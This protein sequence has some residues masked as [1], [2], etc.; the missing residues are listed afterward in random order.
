MGEDQ[1]LGEAEDM[2]G[3]VAHTPSKKIRFEEVNTIY[4]QLHFF[5]YPYPRPSAYIVYFKYNLYNL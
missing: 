3:E 4:I 2:I 1:S 5:P